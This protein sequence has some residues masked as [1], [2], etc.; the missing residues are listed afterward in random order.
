MAGMARRITVA[1]AAAL[2]V[3]GALAA[4]PMALADD[5]PAPPTVVTMLTG[6]EFDAT[7]WLPALAAVLLWFVGVR[8]ANRAHPGRPVAPARTA[9]WLGGVAVLL[10][11]L[12]S[13]IGRY[14]DILFSDHM[15]QH[16]LITLVAAPLLLLAGPV[17]LL[18][19]ASSPE[20]RRRWILP[21]LHARALRVVAH[22]AVAWVVFAAVMWGTHFSS[23]YELSL[24]NDL[25]HNGEHALYLASALLFWWPVVGRDPSPWRLRPAAGVLY[26]G[27]QMPQLTFLSLA[28]YTAPEPLYPHY[29]TEVVAWAPNALADQ[30]LGAAIMWVGGDMLFMAIALLLIVLWMRDEERRAVREDRRL[31]AALAQSAGQPSGGT[32]AAR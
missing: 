11:A 26:T 5:V 31:D 19:Q 17:T 4:A 3:A 24:E 27:L 14:D 10:V 29:A 9:A 30:R 18:L 6:W 2:A 22:P 8:H 12:V 32:G 25:V 16:L 1:I 28:I 7:V 23:L 20:T 15:V 21:V 13:G